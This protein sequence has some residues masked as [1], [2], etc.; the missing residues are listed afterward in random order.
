[1][2]TVR[3][4]TGEVRILRDEVITLRAQ[5]E[6]LRERFEPVE[7]NT[8]HNGRYATRDDIEQLEG[9]LNDFKE[10]TKLS[11]QSTARILGWILRLFAIF[12]T[13]AAAAAALFGILVLRGG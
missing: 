5:Q 1:M 12:A 7:R 11:L 4:L 9:S 10:A 8:V 6:A 13:L 3:E 2:A